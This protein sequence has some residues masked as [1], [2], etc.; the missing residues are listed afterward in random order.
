L[1]KGLRGELFHN[2]SILY[3]VLIVFYIALVVDVSISNIADIKPVVSDFRISMLGIGL[4]VLIA[5]IFLVCQFVI[6]KHSFIPKEIGISPFRKISI[7]KIIQFVQYLLGAILV[8]VI[9]QILLASSYDRLELV[10]AVILS[11]GMATVLMGLLAYRLFEWFKVNKN[12]VTLLFGIAASFTAINAATSLYLYDEILIASQPSVIIP[13]TNSEWK[14]PHEQGD[15]M[16]MVNQLQFISMWGYFIMTYVG[17]IFLLIHHIKKI[18]M[19]RFWAIVIAPLLFF[20]YNY[21]VLFKYVLPNAPDLLPHP[22]EVIPNY[23]I[24]TISIALLGIVIG[25][26]FFSVS[27]SIKGKKAI[28]SS[29]IITAFGF[30][31]YFNAADAT[32][33]HVPYPPYGLACVSIVGF[34]AFLI[35]A[36][37]Y[38]SAVSISRDVQLRNS[39]KKSVQHQ[40]KFLSGMGI[41]QMRQEMEK[42]IDDIIKE[43]ELA[44]PN[45]EYTSLSEEEVKQYANE[46]LEELAKFKISK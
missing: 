44:R 24:L 3:T 46:V 41:A 37:L 8:I 7:F 33:L 38:K 27:Y 25:I 29:L 17:T 32:V 16:V 15:Y 6:M 13:S 31:F 34:S 21:P 45:I 11:Y 22:L 26:G 12:M 39:I 42:S 23:I 1:L 40:F 18:G 19:I 36:G 9:I 35:Y 5:I 14:L 2:K 28:Q 20:V 43:S 4:F 30:I 10:V